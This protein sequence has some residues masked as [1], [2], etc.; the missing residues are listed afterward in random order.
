MQLNTQWIASVDVLRALAACTEENNYVHPG[1][2]ESLD[3]YI[4]EG[5]YPAI[6]KK[7]PLGGVPYISNSVFLNQED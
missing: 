1:L 7:P 2:D 3:L 4:E 5:R 6:E